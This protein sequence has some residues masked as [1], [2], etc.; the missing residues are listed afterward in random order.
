MRTKR[1]GCV[2]FKGE[3]FRF[4]RRRV[5]AGEPSVRQRLS[6][7][8]AVE[9]GREPAVRLLHLLHVRQ[10]RHAQPPQKV[11]IVFSRYPQSNTIPN[12]E[13]DC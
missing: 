3:R 9:R 10:H 12:H 4:R 11:R 2:H 5:E 8:G 1:I 13:M 7:A 6:A